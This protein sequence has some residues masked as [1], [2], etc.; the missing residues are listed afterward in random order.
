MVLLN[1]SLPW[2]CECSQL[3]SAGALVG[4]LR[5]DPLQVDWQLIFLSHCC[6]WPG[7]EHFWVANLLLDPFGIWHLLEFAH[8]KTCG[9]AFNKASAWCPIFLGLCTV[10]IRLGLVHGAK[11]LEV[12]WVGPGGVAV[13][14]DAL[15][16]I[17][18]SVHSKVPSFLCRGFLSTFWKQ[19]A[20]ALRRLF[21]QWHWLRICSRELALPLFHVSKTLVLTLEFMPSRSKCWCVVDCS[22][23]LNRIHHCLANVDVKDCWLVYKLLYSVLALTWL[24]QSSIYMRVINRIAFKV[25]MMLPE[26][27]HPL[28]YFLPHILE[29]LDRPVFTCR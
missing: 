13:T 8:M 28:L 25:F 27:W 7:L 14:V 11:G 20:C 15:F 19:F 5:L 29:W 16:V 10:L 12:D 22:L 2:A 4:S 18:N 17:A 24:E 1:L 6:L 3:P 9:L 26:W 21:A 23:L